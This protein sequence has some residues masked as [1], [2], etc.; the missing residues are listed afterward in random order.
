MSFRNPIVAGQRLIIPAIHSPNYVAPGA[1]M[2]S[3]TTGW[4]IASD[5]TMH[6]K[7]INVRNVFAHNLW[8]SPSDINIGSVYDDPTTFAPVNRF[9]SVLQRV[10]RNAGSEVW[11]AAGSIVG[12]VGS[13]QIDYSQATGGYFFVARTSGFLWG[14]NNGDT[15]QGALVY[16]FAIPPAVPANPGLASAKMDGGLNE[17]NP[18]NGRFDT[19]QIE[20]WFDPPVTNTTYRL[21]VALKVARVIAGGTPGNPSTFTDNASIVLE[22]RGFDPARWP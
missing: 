20:G 18:V 21:K 1:N 9:N 16:E 17:W 7:D 10:V 12:G 15:Y 4:E 5:G 8:T 14:G 19:A 13:F 6:A 3:P 2:N 22:C 11:L